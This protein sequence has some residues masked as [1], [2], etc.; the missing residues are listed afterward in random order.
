MKTALQHLRP[1]EIFD[2]VVTPLIDDYIVIESVKY[3][4]PKKDRNPYRRGAERVLLYYIVFM[5]CAITV[6]EELLV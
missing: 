1:V 5:I 6:K 3:A 4:A 2:E